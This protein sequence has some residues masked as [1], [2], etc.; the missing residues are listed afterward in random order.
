MTQEEKDLLYKDMC[1]RLP[2]GVKVNT[3][4]SNEHASFYRR[5]ACKN[6]VNELNLNIMWLYHVQFEIDIKPYLFPLESMSEEQSKIYH[7][8]IGGMF[9]TSTLINFEALEDFFHENHIDYRGLIP[10]GLAKDATGLNIY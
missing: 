5:R 1:A 8:L 4:Y 9:G 7:E 2:Y 10:K 3:I 6:G